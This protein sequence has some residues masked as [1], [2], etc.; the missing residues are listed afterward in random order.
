MVG[1]AITSCSPTILWAFKKAKTS[2]A[3]L[4]TANSHWRHFEG[5]K[6]TRVLGPGGVVHW[7]RG[8]VYTTQQNVLLSSPPVLNQRDWCCQV[9]ARFCKEWE[10]QR[11]PQ[12]VSSSSSRLAFTEIP[13]NRSRQSAR[14]ACFLVR[15]KNE[16]RH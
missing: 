13:S 15:R 8:T 12:Q 16:S 4:P 5:S 3:C 1:A 6:G 9:L 14:P 10:Y 11:T 7:Q 2:A